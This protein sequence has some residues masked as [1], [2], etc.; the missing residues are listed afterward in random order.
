M[1]DA[2]E[3]AQK[4]I[5]YF[6]TMD[7]EAQIGLFAEDGVDD[8]PF[9]RD[10]YRTLRGRDEIREWTKTLL[11]VCEHVTVTIVEAY[12]CADPNVCIVEADGDVTLT[13]GEHYKNRYVFLFKTRDDKVVLLREYFNTVA[14]GQI[15]ALADPGLVGTE[16][17]TSGS[18]HN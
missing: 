12:R 14:S 13:S 7:L 4:F 11:K 6:N 18:V 3:I 9:D 16:R 2:Y 1:A 8:M 10:G 17:A 15:L 5:G